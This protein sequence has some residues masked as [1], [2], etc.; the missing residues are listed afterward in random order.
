MWF[1]G[2]SWTLITILTSNAHPVLAVV[3]YTKEHAT[4]T[5]YRG[6]KTPGTAAEAAAC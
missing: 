3:V 6:N 2:P 5:R 4:E 1:S